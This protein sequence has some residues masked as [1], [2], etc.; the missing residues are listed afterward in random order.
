MLIE[1]PETCGYKRPQ[2][3]FRLLALFLLG[4]AIAE[5]PLSAERVSAP[6]SDPAAY[7]WV[8]QPDDVPAPHSLSKK[9]AL[10]IWVDA[11]LQ[12]VASYPYGHADEPVLAA[13]SPSGAQIKRVAAHGFLLA[14][15][16]F[17]A[18]A[19]PSN[20]RDPPLTA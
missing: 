6:A 7:T 10:E 13:A 8:A 3:L 11:T 16:L 9:T 5:G 18:P 12:A 4:L 2:A 15:Y 14:T 20:A 17:P 1:T 19:C